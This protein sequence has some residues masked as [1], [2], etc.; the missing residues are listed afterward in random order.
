MTRT[1]YED[2]TL[3]DT[4]TAKVTIEVDGV[5]EDVVEKV[6][7]H[8]RDEAVRALQ[9]CETGAHPSECRGAP[10]GVD[11]DAVLGESDE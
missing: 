8:T 1:S 7:M 11:W 3:P 10:F 2:V 6:A 5:D 4:K 9:A